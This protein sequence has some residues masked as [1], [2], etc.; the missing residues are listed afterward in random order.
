[1][2]GIVELRLSALFTDKGLANGGTEHGC[3]SL[4]TLAQAAMVVVVVNLH[5]D[6]NIYDPNVT[7]T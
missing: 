6:N 4:T 7:N 2:E 5:T 3:L 1:V